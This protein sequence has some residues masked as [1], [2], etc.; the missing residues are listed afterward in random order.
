MTPNGF[1]M[2]GKLASYLLPPKVKPMSSSKTKK[3][4][5]KDKEKDK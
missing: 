2:L 1:K 3:V 4:K 5:K